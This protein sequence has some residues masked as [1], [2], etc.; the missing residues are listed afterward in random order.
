MKPVQGRLRYL[1]TAAALSL[2]G[3]SLPAHALMA[4]SSPDSPGA[5]VDL[6]TADSPFA[7]VGSISTSSGVYSGVLIAP[8]YVLTAAHVAGGLAPSD[9][10]FNLNVGGDLTQRISA[11]QI[12]V[13]PGYTGFSSTHPA[14]GDLAIIKLAQDAAAGT[15]SYGLYRDSFAAGT[16]LTLVG[17]GASGNGDVGIT[18]GPSASVKRVGE[19]NADLFA[20]STDGKIA[21]SL[22]YFDFDGPN[23]TTNVIGGRTLGNTL[24]T[25]VASGDSG[26]PAFIKDSNG[27]WLLAGINTFRW[28]S[29]VTFG[30]G[31]GGQVIS[32]YA[33]WIDSVVTPVPEP[34]P[35]TMLLSA[36]GLV[37]LAA[38]RQRQ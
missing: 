30:N 25:T 37:G 1:F 38:R 2:L 11:A 22:Y 33:G 18:V 17:Y 8:G 10:T 32:S 36:L 15:P 6:N 13:N 35:A 3:A 14:D 19:N 23:Q 27:H 34:S 20:A 24:E 31:G 5:R 16:T 21:R 4:G 26:S 28:G 7:G 9:V 29:D 12:Y